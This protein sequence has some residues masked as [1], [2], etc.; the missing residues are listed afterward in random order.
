MNQGSKHFNVADVAQ[1]RP[2]GIHISPIK[3]GD[4]AG[5]PRVVF[6][7]WEPGVTVAPHTHNCDYC[8]IILEGRQKVGKTWFGVGDV[9]LVKAG[10]GYGPLM[11][12]A[13]GCT[14]II[15]F[16]S[17]DQVPTWL[18]EGKDVA[19]SMLAA[20]AAEGGLSRRRSSR[21]E[22]G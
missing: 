10:T 16:A 14:L 11:A 2:N 21:G 5:A 12:G 8:E 18:P 15:V 22:A 20:K 7:K 19:K 6:A 13:E 17:D 9:R 4:A 1:H 3:V